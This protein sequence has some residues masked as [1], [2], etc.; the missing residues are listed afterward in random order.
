MSKTSE[1]AVTFIR[2]KILEELE[3]LGEVSDDKVEEMIAEEISVYGK[4]N[5]ISINERIMIGKQI[6]H[7]LRKLDILQDLIDNPNV[8]EI[9]VNGSQSIFI[10][11]S[12]RLYKINQQF[13]SQE[14]LKHIIQQIVAKCN[15]V[16]NESS[17]IVDAR[18][19]N[20]SRV[21]VVLNPVAI[22]G[23]ILTIR[24]FPEKP[25]RN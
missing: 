24:R 25:L 6:Y 22:N 14:K 19:Y 15:R 3:Y 8:T 16:V 4:I 21:N 5:Y 7:S 13:E 18:L 17:P 9:M 11:K 20:G 10:E 23:P 1:D 2:A 12:G